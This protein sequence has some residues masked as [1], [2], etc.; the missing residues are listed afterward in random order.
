MMQCP[1]CGAPMEKGALDAGNGP[2]QY[3]NR[4]HNRAVTF[5][6]DIMDGEVD[7]TPGYLFG[8]QR[9]PAY[10]CAG[11]KKI[12]IDYSGEAEKD[13]AFAELIKELKK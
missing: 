6:C 11:C 7:L 3:I 4:K 2:L 13:P 9:I 1:F 12:L 8:S 5:L 10:K